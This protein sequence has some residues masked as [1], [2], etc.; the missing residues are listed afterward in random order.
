MS[1]QSLEERIRAMA[2]QHESAWANQQPQF[3]NTGARLRAFAD[4][5][6][7]LVVFL[8]RRE[9]TLERCRSRERAL[10]AELVDAPESPLKATITK[11]EATLRDTTSGLASALADEN[12]HFSD[13]FRE[14]L[15]GCVTRSR[16]T[17]PGETQ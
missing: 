16:A 13:V 9:A 10:I 1:K 15:E 17:L 12:V 4:E 8:E 11:L 6:E 3:S 5:V 2:A 7:A 14:S